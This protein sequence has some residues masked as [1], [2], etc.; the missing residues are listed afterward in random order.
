LQGNLEAI[1][2]VL[3]YASTI[4]HPEAI[5]KVWRS[6]PGLMK[7]F[8]EIY[9]TMRIH[10]GTLDIASLMESLVTKPRLGTPWMKEANSRR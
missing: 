1:R 7:A 8:L 10:L 5:T 4:H 6:M 3:S 9:F 2:L